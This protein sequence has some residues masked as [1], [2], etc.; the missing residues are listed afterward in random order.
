LTK[1]VSTKITDELYAKL[2]S[3]CSGLICTPS[4]YLTMLIQKDL[5]E[6]KKEE[7]K[8]ESPEDEFERWLNEPVEKDLTRLREARD[9]LDETV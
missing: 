8:K 1:V 6:P 5:A 9:D 2:L 3:K 7:P 4:H